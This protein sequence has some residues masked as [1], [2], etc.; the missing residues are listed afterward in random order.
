M[1][2]KILLALLVLAG[3]RTNA[4]EPQLNVNSKI[5]NVTVF[6]QGAQVQRQSDQVDVPQGVS[7][8]VFSGLSSSIETQSLQAKGEGNFTILSVG[9]QRNFLLEKKKSEQKVALQNKVDEYEDKI[10]KLNNEIA[11]YKAEEEMLMKNQ[12]VTGDYVTYDLVKLKAAL[13]FQKQRLTDTK[14]KQTALA[15]EIDDLRKEMGKLAMQA[16]EVDGKPIGNS[17]DVVVKVSAKVATKGKFTLS[18]LVKN[19][20]WYPSYDIRAIDVTSPIQLV[21]KANVSQNS[22]EDW[23]G[24]KLTLSSGNPSNNNEKPTLPTYSLGYL[25]AGYS[26]FNPV[27][28]TA[29]IVRGRIVDAS[30]NSPL[31]GVSVRVKN[32]S[33]GAATDGDGNYSIQLPAGNNQLEFNYV[34]YDRQELAA[35][36]GQLNVRLNPS[37]NTLNEVVVAGY[38]SK[39]NLTSALEGKVAGTNVKIRGA[40]SISSV[41]LEVKSMEKPTNVTFEIKT[42]YTILSD[43][44]Y[45][46]VDIGNYDFKADYEYY[47][48]PKVT[49]DAFLTAKITDLN[50]VNLISGEASIF[51][52]GT[53][54]GKSLLDVQNSDTLTISL[55]VDKNVSIKREKQKGFTERQFIG[56]SQKDTRHFIIDV[57]NKKSQAINIT[58]EDQVPVSTNSDI[59]V[60]RQEISKAK[61]DETSG[62]LTWQLLLQPNEQKKLDLKYQVKYPKNRPINME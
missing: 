20:N 5:T 7:L 35:Y 50:E 30:D 37:V 22:G 29:N 48:I 10:K 19:A 11:V 46:A 52:E 24:V 2:K 17:S 62:K 57:K 54:L 3:F 60:E 36:S 42:A 16:A 9:K 44:K 13:D 4:Q 31:V 43:G 51:F 34:G 6:M 15:K 12:K 61:F 8:L 21:Y 26:F 56:S 28:A 39:E 47:A 53:Y 55:G 41:P 49:P 40:S 23:K 59:T 14:N 45:A 38:R 25:S 32:S 27:T 18:Y 1:N 33:I 58:I